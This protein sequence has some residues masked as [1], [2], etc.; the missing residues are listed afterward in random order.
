[1]V[2]T[3]VAPRT[4]ETALAMGFAVDREVVPLVGDG[5]AAEAYETN[6][7]WEAAAPFV[8]LAALIAAGGPARVQAAALG[9]LWRDL[10][11]TLPDGAAALLIGHSGQLEAA[12]C[13]GLPDAD[14]ASWGAPFGCC[15]GARL[16]FEGDPPRFTRATMLRLDASG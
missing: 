6:R 1:V 10:L 4:R 15:E 3:S 8:A 9:E 11:T 5:A 13:Y 2:A 14:H 7:W 12:L 16:V